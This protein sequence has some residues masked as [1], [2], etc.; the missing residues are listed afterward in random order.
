M[1]VPALKATEFCLLT[2]ALL[3]L[4]RSVYKYFRSCKSPREYYCWGSSRLL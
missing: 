1:S 2:A 3:A 4:V